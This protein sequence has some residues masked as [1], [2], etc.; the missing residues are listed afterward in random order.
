MLQLRIGFPSG[1]YF[2]ASVDDPRE[3]EWPPHPSRI[4]SALVAAAYAGGRQ[5]TDA[6]RIALQRLESLPPPTL[7]FPDA[8][9]R[10]APDSFVP[11]NDLK[12]RVDSAK[13]KSLG[14]LLPNRQARQFPAAFLL[15]EP[16]VTLQWPVELAAEDIAAL[17]SIAAML[18]HV[19]TSHS[20]ATASF[21]RGACG[22]PRWTP[23]GDGG[24]YLRVPRSG[25]LEELDRLVT[26]GHGTLRRPVPLCEVMWPYAPVGSQGVERVPSLHDWVVLRLADVSW[27]AD[28]AHTLARALRRAVLSILGD[29]APAA[30]HGHDL[31]IAHLVWIPLADVG[32]VHA[33]GRIRGV[34]IGLPWS[35]PE[36]ERAATLAALARLEKLT[37]PDGQIAS[38]CPSLDGPET[39]IALRTRTWTAASCQWSTVTPVILDRPPKRATSERL[40]G[41]IAESLEMAGY[42][43]PGDV[44]VLGSSDFEGAPGALEIPTKVPRFHTRI[45]F[46]V[47]VAGP[48]VAGRWKNFGIG[49]FRPTP[50]VAT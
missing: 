26:R 50:G 12:S 22:V 15:G 43:R 44:Q 42:P 19:G 17:D 9:I 34:G 33:T 47:P 45:R 35:M 7:A 1:R 40:A 16:E 38:V 48:V 20:L 8:D 24:H 30:V 18:T 36:G 21:S 3:P 6:Q 25:R 27:G 41:A 29:D 11:V 28:T 32:H 13:L 39:P 23:Q 49:V 4:F 10:P 5:P 2:G 46:D 37:L 31:D 14:V